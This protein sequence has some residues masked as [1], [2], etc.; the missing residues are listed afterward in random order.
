MPRPWNE[1][2]KESQVASL[3]S[4]H[5]PLGKQHP[6]VQ[7]ASKQLEPTPWNTP[8]RLTQDDSFITSAQVSSGKQHAPAELLVK[9]ASAI[10]VVPPPLKMP[11]RRAHSVANESA[12]ASPPAR[13]QAPLSPIRQGSE[14]QS[15]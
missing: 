2:P 13:Q 6:P 4:S 12:Q 9:Q 8:P 15:S 1:P 11:P 7:G 14:E 10:Q 5:E 3:L